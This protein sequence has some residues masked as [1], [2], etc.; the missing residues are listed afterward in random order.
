MNDPIAD[1]LGI[2]PDLEAYKQF[3]KT[4]RPKGAKVVPAF[5]IMKGKN[6]PHFGKPRPDSVKKKIRDT[7]TGQPGVKWT[8]E[9][10]IKTVAI[11]KKRSSFLKLSGEQMAAFRRG[12]P[13]SEETKRKMRE[14]QKRRRIAEKLNNA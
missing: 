6:H 12:K 13:H 3:K 4:R 8:E 2:K 9:R 1:A 7:K 11:L 5:P 10:R 14:S